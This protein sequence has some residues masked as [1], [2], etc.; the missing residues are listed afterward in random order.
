MKP[1]IR[2]CWCERE[3]A[4]HVADAEAKLGRSGRDALPVANAV[5]GQMFTL[6][7]SMLRQ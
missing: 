2:S 6:K 5:I 4:A 3:L 1:S 7:D